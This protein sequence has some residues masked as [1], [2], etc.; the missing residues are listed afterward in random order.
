MTHRLAE[1][2]A[3][4]RAERPVK[5]LA[6]LIESKPAYAW[7]MRCSV[8]LDTSC[9]P[10]ISATV[11]L[12]TMSEKE[13]RAFCLSCWLDGKLTIDQNGV[14]IGW[15][16]FCCTCPDGSFSMFCRNHGG[17]HG[18]NAC[19]THGQ[20]ATGCNCDYCNGIYQP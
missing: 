4:F 20:P 16:C 3:W 19:I 6:I 1:V 17:A 7:C 18:S 8:R 5:P 15:D 10:Y 14:V 13:T 9:N 12:A 2:R 11:Q